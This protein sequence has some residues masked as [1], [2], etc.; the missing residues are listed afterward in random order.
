MYVEP[1][2]LNL[3]LF[4]LDLKPLEVKSNGSEVKVSSAAVVSGYKTTCIGLLVF[5][6]L[7]NNSQLFDATSAALTIKNAGL[8]P[9]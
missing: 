1:L 3:E 2:P 8:N 5:L 6:L 7:S 4:F 9:V